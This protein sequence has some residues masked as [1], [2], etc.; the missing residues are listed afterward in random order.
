M[1]GPKILALTSSLP[2]RL[3]LTHL[4]FVLSQPQALIHLVEVMRLAL[5]H[6]APYRDVSRPMLSYLIL[7]SIS[8]LALAPVLQP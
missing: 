7:L 2:S 5:L 4:L 8:Q 1:T 3:R 6:E